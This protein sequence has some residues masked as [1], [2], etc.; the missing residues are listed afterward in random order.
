AAGPSQIIVP[1]NVNNGSNIQAAELHQNF[2]SFLLP[3]TAT[4]SYNL[5]VSDMSDNYRSNIQASSSMSDYQKNQG[6]GAT[7]EPYNNESS[8]TGKS[9]EEAQLKNKNKKI[10]CKW[11]DEPTVMLL[12]YLK[13]YKVP[14]LCYA[15]IT[16]TI[17]LRNS[18]QIGGKI[19]NRIMS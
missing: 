9:C 18:A 14:P 7:T 19:L 13:K 12:K 5:T 4:G 1:A 16:T 6:F 2:P 17:I 3:S 11:K 10:P 8:Q 15:K